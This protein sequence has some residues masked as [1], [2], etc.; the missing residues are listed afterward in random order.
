R[1]GTTSRRGS[2][3]SSWHCG[4]A[5]RRRP[6]LVISIVPFNRCETQ[7]LSEKNSAAPLRHHPAAPS[8]PSRPPGRNDPAAGDDVESRFSQGL[9]HSELGLTSARADEVSLACPPRAA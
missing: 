6:R 8:E 3:S 9:F 5:V 4:A 1:P 7:V 2:R